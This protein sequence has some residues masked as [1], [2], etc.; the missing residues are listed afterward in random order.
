MI[1]QSSPQQVLDLDLYGEPNQETLKEQSRKKT[2]GGFCDSMKCAGSALGVKILK[3]LDRKHDFC[4]D[5]KCT[6]FW[7]EVKNGQQIGVSLSKK[8]AISNV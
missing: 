4:P 3:T 1:K 7:A 6:L 5:C 2:F 8:N